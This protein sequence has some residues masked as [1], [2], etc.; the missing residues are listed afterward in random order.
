MKNSKFAIF[1]LIFAL[2]LP[3]AAQNVTGMSD[4]KLFIDAGHSAKENQGLY[5]YSEA[6]KTRQVAVNIKDFLTTYTD[7]PAANIKLCREN[8]VDVVSLIGRTDMANAWDAD[9][10]YSVHSDA[11]AAASNST[12]TMYGGWKTDGTVVEKTP[13]GGKVYGEILCP[14]L[15]GVMGISTRGN[16]ADRTYYDAASNHANKYPYLSVNRESNMASL[17]SEAG[18]HTNPFQQMRNLNAGY[19]RLEAYAAYQSLVKFL[20]QKY[21]TAAANPPQIGIATGVISDGETGLAINGATINIGT[22][23]YTTDTYES[24]FH[25]YSNDPNELRNGFYF[26]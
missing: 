4:I 18:F 14:N 2:A 25:S 6:E 13:D 23:S 22:E 10:Y 21:G 9:F 26:I 19:K 20:S 11:G 3:A 16:M 12:L 7:M 8:D 24:L 1:A 17:L 5:K 15:T